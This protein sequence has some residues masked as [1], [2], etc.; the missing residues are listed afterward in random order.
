M[1]APPGRKRGVNVLD[2]VRTMARRR[3]FRPLVLALFLL[4]A[5]SWASPAREQAANGHVTTLRSLGSTDV[6]SF[7]ASM[8]ADRLLLFEV[9]KDLPS[10]RSDAEAYLKHLKE[11]A[12]LSDAARLVP[13]VNRM[14]EQAPTYFDWLEKNIQN[15][16]EN[17]NEYVVGGARGF[18]VAFQDFQNEVML[19]VIN[20]LEIAGNALR[21]A[22]ALSPG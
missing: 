7:L 5:L 4:P 6:R 3:G 14:I 10:K 15:Q 16:T 9:R 22:T 13:K 17:Q 8:D 1:R 2:P 20:R 21:E 11:L 12:A 19:I 18:L